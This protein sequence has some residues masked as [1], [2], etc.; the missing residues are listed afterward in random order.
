M[1]TSCPV[2]GVNWQGKEVVD[3]LRDAGNPNP[4]E[5][6]KLYGWTPENKLRFSI[7]VIGI[8]EN[9]RLVAWKCLVC[10]SET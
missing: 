8:E 10:G 5:A 1:K 4:E 9:D 6:A 7:N 2:C 3:G